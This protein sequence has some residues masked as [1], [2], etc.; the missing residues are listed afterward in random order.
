[1]AQPTMN[2]ENNH[3]DSDN[4]TQI[5]NPSSSTCHDKR[6]TYLNV[7][8]V[9]QVDSIE[10]SLN[11]GN[12]TVDKVT[13]NRNNNGTQ[14]TAPNEGIL[15][16]SPTDPNKS[17]LS[18][19]RP[20]LY[21]KLVTREPSRKSVNFRT[22]PASTWNRADVAIS[23]ES[24]DVMDV[25]LENDP[26]FIHNNAFNLKKG[27]PSV[28]LLKEDVGIVLVWIMLHGVPITAFI[29]DALRV[30]ATKLGTSVMLDS[31]TSDMCMQSWGRSSYSRS[32]IEL[33]AD[34]ELKDTIVVL[35][36]NLL[37]RGSICTLYVLNMSKNLLGVRVARYLVTF[38]MS[39][40]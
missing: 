4:V 8:Q 16:D 7:E 9:A 21:A 36:Q 27:N 30:I 10:A 38:W 31:Y 3:T 6:P 15:T 2:K 19:S 28:N 22:L 12:G 5:S 40:L 24:N 35:C 26:W 33:R 14:E 32:M 23:L 20:T 18:F 37:V 34:V 17:G 39:V 25:M 29:K 1:M 13:V 11:T